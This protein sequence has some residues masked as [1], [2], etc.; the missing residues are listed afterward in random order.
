VAIRPP[1]AVNTESFD[2]EEARVFAASTWTPATNAYKILTGLKP[3]PSDPAAVTATSTPNGFV[4]V[5]PA[6]L[7]IQ[8]SRAANGGAYTLTW[9]ATVD[10]NILSTP[11]N[12]TNPRND[13]IIA[14][15]PDTF[16]GDPN[17]TPVVRQVVGT[18]SGSPSDPSLAAF[19]DAVT[20]A[21]VRVNA[22]A[23]TITNSNITD[24]RPPHTVAV[25]GVLPVANA[26]ARNALTGLYD[27]LTIYRRDRDWLETYDGTAWRV[28]GVAK[29]S[30]FADLTN[31]TSPYTGQYAAT[32]DGTIY[33]R[34]A[35][36][37]RHDPYRATQT[38]ASAAASITFSSIPSTLRT[39]EV[40]WRAKSS[41]AATP[42]YLQMRVDGSSAASYYDHLT[43]WIG[44]AAPTV[45]QFTAQ[46]ASRV[47][48]IHANNASDGNNFSVG[49]ALIGAWHAPAADP[50]VHWRANSGGMAGAVGHQSSFT[51][52]I[53]LAGPHTS[54][55]F[56]P[57]LGNFMTGTEITIKG[58]DQ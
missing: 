8:S 49:H 9:D 47:G 42:R 33:R 24:L 15:T 18:P 23:T 50:S 57:D 26:T 22:S 12:A 44:V 28:H 14:W 41:D 46:T 1:F 5:A 6:T 32:G 31:I 43:Y 25:G 39:I 55:T 29:V 51:G 45:T 27:G 58:Y 13:L 35:S 19:P 36:G 10:I 11:A 52:T 4:H 38:L 48:L 30:S 34:D 56:F 54:L 37:W 40:Q 7:I 53:A 3:G 2:V 20:L 17:S 21:R 16:Y